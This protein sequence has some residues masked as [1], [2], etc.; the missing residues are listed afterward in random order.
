MSTHKGYV[1]SSEHVA[2]RVMSRSKN[3]W[4]RNHPLYKIWK[5]MRARCYC[6][7]HDQFKHYG[8]R[9]IGICPEWNDFWQF[10]KDMGER[11]SLS[12]T[13]D[14]IELNGNYEPGNVRWATWTEQANN[15]SDNVRVVRNGD[16]KTMSQWAREVGVT[17]STIRNRVLKGLPVERILAAASR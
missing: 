13:I 6:K 2:K 12:H 17:P 3:T 5:A 10:A 14:R 1:Q 8:G 4:R 11:P 15:R 9:G 7:G 16:S